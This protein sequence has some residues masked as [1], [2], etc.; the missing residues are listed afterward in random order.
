MRDAKKN[1]KKWS[2]QKWVP[3]AGYPWLSQPS[4]W[5]RF[6][7]L[8]PMLNEQNI[9]NFPSHRLLDKTIEYKHRCSPC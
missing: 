7:V 6:R 2:A 1:K 9:T 5:P 8:Q 4:N 3:R